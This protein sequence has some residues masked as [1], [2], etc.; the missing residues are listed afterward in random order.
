MYIIHVIYCHITYRLLEALHPSIRRASAASRLT[1]LSSPDASLQSL[2][3]AFSAFR[4]FGQLAS[5]KGKKTTRFDT[6]IKKKIKQILIRCQASVLKLNSAS[7]EIVSRQRL[8][9]RSS[10][11]PEH[12]P[13]CQVGIWELNIV[14]FGDVFVLATS[15]W[16]SDL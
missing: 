13:S 11:Q 2:S 15:L 9:L 3:L 10:P 4:R 14:I 5:G 16:D 7:S 8:N 6:K 12:S 1:G